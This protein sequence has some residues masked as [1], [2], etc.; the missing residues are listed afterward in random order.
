MSDQPSFDHPYVRT[1]DVDRFAALGADERLSQSL[2]SAADGA[3]PVSVAYIR[4]PPG[5]GS[6]EGLHYHEVQQVFYVIKGVM[7]IEV[8]GQHSECG[9]GSLIVFPAGIHHRNW[10]RTDEETIHLNICGPA[11]DPSRPFAFRVAD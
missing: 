3:G 8:D 1:V 7:S 5:G 4:T 11:P 6:P 9:P 2:L 10:N